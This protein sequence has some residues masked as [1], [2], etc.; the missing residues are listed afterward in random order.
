MFT[1]AIHGGAVSLS[2]DSL[3]PEQEQDY[4][5]GLSRAVNAGY[6]I[7]DAGGT[8]LDATQQ[9]VMSLE[10]NALFNAGKGAV[11]TNEQTHELEAAMMCGQ[12]RMAGAVAGVTNVRNPI[13]LARAIMDQSGHVFMVGPGAESFARQQN[14]SFEPDAYFF[15]QK[16]LDE[17]KEAEAQTRQPAGLGTVGAVALDRYGNLAAATSTGGLTYQKVGRVGDS[18]V[19]GGGTYANNQTCAV[20]CTGDGEYFIR[21]VAAY[22]VSC[23]IEYKGLSLRDACQHVIMD[24]LRQLKGEGGLIA[25]DPA[26]QVA[27]VFNSTSMFRAWRNHQEEGETAIFY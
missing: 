18:P 1:I 25:V 10:D 14:L 23:L 17:F 12:T 20:S 5:N 11:F 7:L 24:K 22:D 4:L 15:T 8:A 26:G 27:L 21:A 6:A 2:R 3:T 9:A 16:R 19:V 13:A